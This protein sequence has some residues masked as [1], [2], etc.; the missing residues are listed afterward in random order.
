M[1]FGL[2]LEQDV[3]QFLNGCKQTYAIL[4]NVLNTEGHKIK[5]STNTTKC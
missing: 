5:I 2:G 4:C 3:W 1:D